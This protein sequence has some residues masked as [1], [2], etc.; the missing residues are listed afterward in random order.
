MKDRE[1]LEHLYEQ[2]DITSM[3]YFSLEVLSIIEQQKKE[4]E[5][6]L[7]YC[8]EYKKEI[9]EL[10]SHYTGLQEYD[11]QIEKENKKLKK[12]LQQSK[13]KLNS[14]RF[15][16]ESPSFDIMELVEQIRE[17]LN[18]PNHDGI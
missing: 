3:Y 18:D 15:Y 2:E 14:I 9:E 8:L 16:V 5:Q 13:I 4:V 10:N 7:E 11:F 17:V 6:Y 1:R 12:E